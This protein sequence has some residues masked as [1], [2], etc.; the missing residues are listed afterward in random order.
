[1]DFAKELDVETIQVSVA[2]AYPGTELYD[3]AVNQVVHRK[4]KTRAAISSSAMQS[5]ALG[6][7]VGEKS[8]FHQL[9]GLGRSEPTP[10]GNWK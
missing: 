2:H 5:L 3:F 7:V 8:P 10:L 6:S 9:T 4:N 1:M